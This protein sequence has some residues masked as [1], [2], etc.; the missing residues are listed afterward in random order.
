MIPIR[1]VFAIRRRAALFAAVGIV[2]GMSVYA[3]PRL[4][5][6]DPA[7]T[8]T[9]L[10]DETQAFRRIAFVHEEIH[11]RPGLITLAYPRWIPGEHGP[12]GPIQNLAAL[13]VHSGDMTLPWARDPDDIYAFRIEVP[14]G[15]D[16][17][18]VDFDTLLE[19]TISD[20]Q[21]LL[22][23]NT[24]VLYPLGI[25]KRTLMI[26]P[27]LLLPSG[28]KFGV[29]L[30]VLSQVGDQVNFAPVSL[31]RLIDSP[32]PAGEFF[33]AAPLTSK[34]PAELDI[35]G[36]SQSA[37]DRADDAN[38]FALFGR[39]IDQDQALFGFRHW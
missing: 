38:A 18:T 2:C 33:R 22:A 36:D 26:A 39:L 28:W 23:W 24:A 20:H 32:V 34:W 30:K 13:R 31:E 9:L 12:T 8:M 27:S 6:L 21:L 14:T 16:T 17:I 5:A 3:G 10:V 37:V 29:S 4:L 1:K 25:D 19:N 35:T 11:V 15:T 7:P